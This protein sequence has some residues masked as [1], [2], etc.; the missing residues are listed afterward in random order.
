MHREGY[1]HKAPATVLKLTSNDS[2]TSF[3]ENDLLILAVLQSHSNASNNNEGDI[4]KKL[5]QPLTP[6][7][8]LRALASSTYCQISK[9]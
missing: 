5:F 2:D 7:K 9:A 1:R 3:L 6:I 4:V 8:P